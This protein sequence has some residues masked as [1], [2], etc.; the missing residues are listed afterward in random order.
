MRQRVPCRGISLCLSQLGSAHQTCDV[1]GHFL[2][3]G[4]LQQAGS[5][6]R[7][8]RALPGVAGV[9]EGVEESLPG[10]NRWQRAKGSNASQVE[11]K[12]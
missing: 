7:S 6:D 10:Q 8:N 12:S 11:M 3:V 5:I 4:F 2:W 9:A 1:S